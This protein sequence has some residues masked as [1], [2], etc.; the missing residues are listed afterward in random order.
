M[1]YVSLRIFY[2]YAILP[3][4]GIY[5]ESIE[6]GDS[7]RIDGDEIVHPFTIGGESYILLFEDYVDSGRTAEYIDGFI[8]PSG[9]KFKFVEPI[10]HTGLSPS[11]DSRQLTAQ[12]RYCENIT[13]IFTLLSIAH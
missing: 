7:R 11:Y 13:G 5:G 3:R 8:L 6:W 10:V 12:A 2:K 1:D 4:F 9:T